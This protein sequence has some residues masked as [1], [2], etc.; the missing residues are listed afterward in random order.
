[1]GIKLLFCKNRKKQ[2]QEYFFISHICWL[3]LMTIYRNVKS[4][5]KKKIKDTMTMKFLLHKDKEEK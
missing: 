1:M 4:K 3:S 2:M 5:P